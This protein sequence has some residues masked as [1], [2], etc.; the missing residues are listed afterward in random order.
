[1]TGGGVSAEAGAGDAPAEPLAF[2]YAH[3]LAP[4]LWVM[5][6]LGCAELLVIHLVVAALW[7]A[8]AALA[9]TLATLGALAWLV[10]FIRSMKRLP[11]LVS[12]REVTMRAG[13]LKSV[14]VARSNLAG[15]ET[16]FPAGF[17]RRPGVLNLGLLAYPNVALALREPLAMKRRGAPVA[18]IAH[19]LD[20]PAGFTAALSPV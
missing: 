20:D 1:V 9:L 7:S 6:A 3:S 11:V 12:E 13:V 4:M 17:V 19:R 2:S 10:Y 8:M 15:I 5:V 14:A 18:W 16:R